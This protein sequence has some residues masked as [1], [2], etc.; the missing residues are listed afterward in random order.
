[1]VLNQHCAAVI[2]T[3][4][5]VACL[6]AASVAGAQANRGRDAGDEQPEPVYKSAVIGEFFYRDVRPVEGV[7][8]RLSFALALSVTEEQ[9]AQAAQVL[10]NKLHRI[11][12]AVLT[13][14]RLCRVRNYQETDL[15]T[16]RRRI[17]TQV[18]RIA[19]EL[20]RGDLLISDFAYFT[21]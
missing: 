1:M 10:E 11:R 20:P 13:A 12:N 21:D 3:T 6:T 14:M 4:V 19:P 15:H 5:A 18:H 8:V 17:W 2:R 16:L 9:H 7:K